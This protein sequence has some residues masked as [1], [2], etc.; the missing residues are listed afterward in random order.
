MTPKGIRRAVHEVSA[1]VPGKTIEE[2]KRDYGLSDVVKLG[3]NENPYGPFPA[4]RRAMQQ[5]VDRLHSYPDSSF[6]EIKRLLGELHGVRP[7]SVAI[8]HGAGG[9]LETIARTFIE[10]GDEVLLPVETYGLYREISRLMGGVTVEVPVTADY[11]IDLEA[12][13]QRI[14]ERTKLAWLCNPNNPTSTLFD[15]EAYAAFRD[16]L[17]ETAW[18][19]LDEAYVEFAGAKT[20]G[21]AADSDEADGGAALPDAVAELTGH[22]V[23]VVRTFS[24]AYGLAGARLGYAMARPEVIRVID[25]VAEPFN[26]NRIG[27]AGAAAVLRE[28]GEAYTRAL[29]ATLAERARLTAA[30]CARGYKVADSCTNFVFF[31]TGADANTLATRMLERGVIVRSC[32]SWGY[33]AHL[34]VTVGKPEHTERFL[35][36]LDAAISALRQETV[37]G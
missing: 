18:I 37:Y 25:T 15:L 27:L 30:L 28:D 9:M 21:E 16:A 34:R 31:D 13:T 17:P 4:S 1:Y 14:S 22:N 12:M 26:A 29:E 11:R 33:P 5:E 2:V 36:V 6:E 8:S 19:V 20:G 24:K 10:E 3:S 32:A 35:A 23:I 7:D